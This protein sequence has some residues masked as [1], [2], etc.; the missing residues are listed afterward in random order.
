MECPACAVVNDAGRRYCR[1]C[2]GRL[3]QPCGVCTFFNAFEDR[4]CGGCG[5]RIPAGSTLAAAC[6]PADVEDLAF[7]AGGRTAPTAVAV[8]PSEID[9]LFESILD[10]DPGEDVG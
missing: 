3:G 5:R 1:A 10:K 4:H 6:A 9:G 8:S 2:G 7:N